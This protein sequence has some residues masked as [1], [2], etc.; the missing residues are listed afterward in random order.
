MSVI[1][2]VKLEDFIPAYRVMQ[3]NFQIDIWRDKY[4]WHSRIEHMHDAC[5]TVALIDTGVNSSFS[6]NF[7]SRST[8]FVFTGRGESPW[9]CSHHPHG[10][11]MARIIS[12]LDPFCR[13][14]ILKVSETGR[15][16]SAERLTEVCHWL[17]CCHNHVIVSLMS[18]QAIDFARNAKADIISF[19][20]TLP[21][22]AF[23]GVTKDLESTE[24]YKNLKDAL[25]RA[26]KDQ[27]TIF[28]SAEGEGHTHNQ[29]FPATRDFEMVTSIAASTQYGTEAPGSLMERANF[30]FPGTNV[31]L[32]GEGI[33]GLERCDEEAFSTSVATAVAAGVASLMLACHRLSIYGA[34]PDSA[35]ELENQQEFNSRMQAQWDREWEYYHMYR[36]DNVKKMFREM[37][38]SP[39]KSVRPE[40]FFKDDH[41]GRSWATAADTL[42]WARRLYKKKGLIG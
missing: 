32:G 8:S 9:F 12:Q 5:S 2:H 26:E 41:E 37:A 11:Q 35:E 31:F 27:I 15:D 40:D 13:L 4:L 6:A 25:K 14:L 34:L 17:C 10:T 36:A 1:E 22:N 3:S 18:D 19:S 23:G 28:A 29:V 38:V 42:E 7:D 24:Q 33:D 20:A 39:T 30:L 21:A 16:I